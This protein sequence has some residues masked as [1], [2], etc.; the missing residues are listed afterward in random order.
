[1]IHPL[2]A[3]VVRDAVSAVRA[4]VVVFKHPRAAG[5]MVGVLASDLVVPH[6]VIAIPPVRDHDLRNVVFAVIHC[7]VHAMPFLLQ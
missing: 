4:G 6:D 7:Q 2:P 3:A 5:P 1:M